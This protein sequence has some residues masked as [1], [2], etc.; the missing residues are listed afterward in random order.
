MK[1]YLG[2]LLFVLIATLVFGQGNCQ[3]VVYLKNGSIIRGVIVEQIRNESFKIETADSNIFVFQM[4]EVE[5]LT[6]ELYQDKDSSSL[7]SVG[8][9][10]G[11]KGVVELGYQIGLTEYGIDRLKLDFING[12]QINPF[13]SLGIG[14]GVRYYFD[15]K[16]ALIPVFADFRA[17]LINRNVSPYFSIGVGYSFDATIKFE[18]VGFLLNPTFGIS[19]KF[20]DATILKLGLGYEM[21]KMKFFRYFLNQY[22]NSYGDVFIENSGVISFSVGIVLNEQKKRA[23]KK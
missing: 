16:A 20:S 14:T 1:K 15:A 10:P 7:N 3:D 13:F 12:Y 18:P 22:G 23:V 5:K 2:L 9:Y 8:L 11:Y 19:L 6:K 21:Q 4:D 17:N